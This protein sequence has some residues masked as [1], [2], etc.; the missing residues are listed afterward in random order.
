MLTLSGKA[1]SA[2]DRDVNKNRSMDFVITLMN[3]RN[4][5]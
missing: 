5:T 4:R 2:F 3:I 1:L